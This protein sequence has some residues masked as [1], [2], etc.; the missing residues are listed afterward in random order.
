MMENIVAYAL[1]C[2]DIRQE[3]GGKHS[4]MGVYNSELVLNDIPSSLSKLH[5]HVTI[6]MPIN[7][8]IKDLGL[9]VFLNGNEMTSL[10][11][12]EDYIDALNSFPEERQD[13]EDRGK[14]A[15]VSL[16][17]LQVQILEEG[18]L[19]LLVEVDGEKIKGNGLRIRR[20][21]DS[22]TDVAGP[23]KQPIQAN[24]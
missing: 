13:S 21:L 19:T 2:D 1:Y 16:E 9:H 5:A 10:S 14:T 11:F 23:I 15:V 12:P 17:F 24:F 6:R 22:E 18:K 4:F 20:K 3:S 7:T 8:K